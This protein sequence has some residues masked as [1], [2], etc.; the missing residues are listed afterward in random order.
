MITINR[1]MLLNNLFDFSKMGS[2]VIVGDPGV[3]KSY[4]LRELNRRYLEKDILSVMIR[5]DNLFDASDNAIQGELEL[6]ENWIATFKKIKILQENKALL[7]F[8]G[9]DAARNET[10]RNDLLKQIKKATVDLSNKWN[11][12]VSVRTYDAAKSQKLIQLFPPTEDYPNNIN[13][14]KLYIPKLEDAE[15]AQAISQNSTLSQ[16]YNEST[17]ALKE[18]LRVPFFLILL[19][20]ILGDASEDEIRKVKKFKSE[21]QLLEFYWTKKVRNTSDH[22]I[23]EK[24]LLDLT[25]KFIESKSLSCS[26][27]SFLM[28]F[29]FKYSESFEYLRRENIIDEVSVGGDHIAFSHNI[30]FD[31]AVS[32]LCLTSDIKEM[33]EFINEDPSRPFFLRPSFIYFF[34]QL[35]YDKRELFWTLFKRLFDQK[36]KVIQLFV[37]LVLMGVISSEYDIL[38]ELT[39]LTN[40]ADT[41]RNKTIRSFLQSIRFIRKKTLS[42]DIEVLGYLSE[43]LDPEFI[44]DFSF[45]LDR[46]IN[47]QGGIETQLN[48]L[49]K[50]ARNFLTYV[51]KYKPAK[52]IWVIDRLGASKGVELVCKTYHTDITASRGLLRSLFKLL[53]QPD[54]EIQYFTNLSEYVREILSYDPEFVAEIYDVLFRHKE[55]SDAKTL[56][57]STITANFIS[58]RKQDFETCYYRLTKFYPDFLSGA[59]YQAIP[60]GLRVV[61]DYVIRRRQKLYYQS[62]ERHFRFKGRD[63]IFIGDLS[64]IWFDNVRY[65]EPTSI[66]NQIISYFEKLLETS[67]FNHDQLKEYLNIYIATSKVG[68]VWKVL[69]DFGSKVVGEFPDYFFD[70]CTEEIFLIANETSYE[71]GKLIENGATYFNPEQIKNIEENIHRIAEEHKGLDPGYFLKKYLSRLPQEKLQLEKSKR[72]IA[73]SGTTGNV[74]PFESHFSSEPYTTDKWLQDRGVNIS[75]KRVKNLLDRSKE[76]QD[77]NKALLSGVPQKENY[78]EAFDNGKS[79]FYEIKKDFSEISED[80]A[81][82]LLSEISQTFAIISRQISILN[83]DEFKILKEIVLF[84]YN[85]N[86]KYDVDKNENESPSRGYSPTPRIVAAEG[87]SQIVLRE[88][89]AENIKILDSAI[90]SSNSIIRFQA[91]RNLKSLFEKRHDYFWKVVQ[92]RLEREDEPLTASIILQSAL[93]IP[94][95]EADANKI[96]K[97]AYKKEKLFKENNPFLDNFARDA[98]WLYT[99]HRNKLADEILSGA[100][101]REEFCKTVIFHAFEQF[102][103]SS[104][105][106]KGEFF[107][108]SSLK[109]TLNYL[110]YI[111]ENLKKVSSQ[112]FK[113]DNQIVKNSLDLIDWIIQ[114]IYFVFE[115]QHRD[116]RTDIP[117]ENRKLLYFRIKPIFKEII[118]ISS[119]IPKGGLITAHTAY[120][121]IETLNSVLIHD[122][123][124]ILSMVSSITKLSV[125]TGYTF[126]SMAIRGVVNLTETLL[127]DY[128]NLLTEPDSFNNLIDL[129]DIYINSGWVDALELLWKLDEIFR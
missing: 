104:L 33:L 80:L 109:W 57:S 106:G 111:R 66:A 101:V 41:S 75:N 16:F 96:F 68:Y 54:F 52:S 24:I 31:Y 26:K 93:S 100:Y 58:N 82:S 126:D 103:I 5:I 27:K 49:G 114:R 78:T 120:Y 21:T 50:S 15:V 62:S 87:L 117:E 110:D 121:F 97:I 71:V 18:M 13:C 25:K 1:D 85:Y 128:R 43:S 115:R 90:N 102:R 74:R 51:L 48:E 61:N 59:P 67:D 2:G 118:E 125:Q 108:D 92:S 89:T 113:G 11:I 112:E 17:L 60:V 42:Q 35:W 53:K 65:N 116:N 32:A 10:F 45:L 79:L 105:N 127:A 86:S 107:I 30:F 76:L 64:S 56:M 8:D 36:D 22:I 95:N 28:G 38:A 46:A 34:T 129:L 124:D 81:F 69:I 63:C 91:I 23:K 37:R 88:D 73:N 6:K 55:T 122:P 39:P 44:W 20:K 14:R 72:I 47:E 12:L 123:K 3:G 99:S 7:I 29:D 4:L 70:F 40:Y 119:G 77:F 84:C 19:D 9:F 98:I 83:E 94:Y